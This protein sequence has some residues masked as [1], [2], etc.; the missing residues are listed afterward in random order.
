VSPEGPEPI[1]A[2][3]FPEVGCFDGSFPVLFGSIARFS[4]NP[5]HKA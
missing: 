3:F 5:D 4:K 1:T 2:I